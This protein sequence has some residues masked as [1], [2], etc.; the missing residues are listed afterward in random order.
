MKRLVVS[1]V[2]IAAFVFYAIFSRGEATLPAGTTADVVASAVSSGSTATQSAGTQSTSQSASTQSTS[3]PSRT[4]TTTSS[5]GYKDGT[6][7]GSGA[8]HMYGTVQVRVI[9]E[10][11]QIAGIQFLRLP[12]GRGESD[13]MSN[14]AAPILAREAIAAQSADVQVISGATLTSRAFMESLQAALDQA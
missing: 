11:G 14:Y 6:Y 3:A 9:I 8:D 12:S 1:A 4:T 5:S 7:T 13:E 2:V 10:G